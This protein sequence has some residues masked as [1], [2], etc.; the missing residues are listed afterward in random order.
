MSTTTEESIDRCST[1]CI[2]TPSCV[3]VNFNADSGECELL[4]NN[5]FATLTTRTGWCRD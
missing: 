4:D 2:I 5:D 3:G 1:R